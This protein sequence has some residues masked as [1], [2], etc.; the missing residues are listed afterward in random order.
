MKPRTNVCIAV[1]NNIWIPLCKE[2]DNTKFS[3]NYCCC[4]NEGKDRRGGGWV[5]LS[6]FLTHHQFR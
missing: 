4:C 2:G 3:Y 5:G 1:D 6:N